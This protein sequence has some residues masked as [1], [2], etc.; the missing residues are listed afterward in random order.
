VSAP[1][2]FSHP[3]CLD[4]DPGAHHP[5]RPE[6]LVAVER[7]LERRGWLGYERRPAPVAAWDALAAVHAPDYVA[8]VRALGEGPGG[9][10]DDTGE[11]VVGPGSLEAALR[12]AG[13]ACEMARALLAGEA[14]AAVCAVRPPGHHAG[15]ASTSGFCLLNNVAVAARYALDALGARRVAIVDWD[16]HH[17]DGTNAIFR[18]SDDVLYASIHQSGIFPGTGRLIDVGARGGEGYSINLPVPAGAGE[19]AWL[20]LL[21]W[22]VVPAVA[23]LGPDLILIS[24][25]FDAHRDD[26]LAGCELEAGSFAEMARHLRALGE[27]VGAPV[28]AVLEG[29]Y[30]L[31]AL[32]DSVAATMAALAGDEEPGSVAPDFLTSRAASHIGHYWRL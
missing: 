2:Y 19:E 17:G 11:T 23:E 6:R 18:A 31:G 29:G 3:A 24:A 15:P 7:E 28:G 25:G 32:A 30:A 22:I 12:A 10:L 1:L 9:P 20:S 26:P 21:E 5:E 14:R 8:T 16:V 4:H 13:G 27:R